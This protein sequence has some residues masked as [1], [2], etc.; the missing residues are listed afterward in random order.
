M[1]RRGNAAEAGGGGRGEGDRMQGALDCFTNLSR[2]VGK[3][4]YGEA[5]AEAERAWPTRERAGAGPLTSLAQGALTSSGSGRS[6]TRTGGKRPSCT[7]R[8]ALAAR[9]LQGNP[10][11][12]APPAAVLGVRRPSRRAVIA[13]AGWRSQ[14]VSAIAAGHRAHYAPLRRQAS[15]LS[16]ASIWYGT[17]THARYRH[18]APCP[19]FCSS[20][21]ILPQKMAVEAS[22]RINI[23]P[24]VRHRTCSS[25]PAQP[26]SSCHA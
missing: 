22:S 26:S 10:C 3:R 2:K 8:V 19:T 13:Q 6:W 5:A 4:R 1:P 17:R 15:R 12:R 21:Y 14:A 7:K 23:C 18:Q 25:F 16:Q 20:F 11:A 9:I 24:C